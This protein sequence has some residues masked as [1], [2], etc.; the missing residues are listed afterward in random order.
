MDTELPIEGIGQSEEQQILNKPKRNKRKPHG[1]RQ[2]EGFRRCHCGDDQTVG[3]DAVLI[4]RG[5]AALRHGLKARPIVG[6]L[7]GEALGLDLAE[8]RNQTQ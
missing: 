7:P 1:T 8:S 6:L 3:E 5:R 2:A 4:R